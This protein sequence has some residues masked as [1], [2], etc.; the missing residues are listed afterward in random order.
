[1]VMLYRQETAILARTPTPFHVYL[2][3]SIT[4]S[5]VSPGTH[6]QMVMLRL[7]ASVSL[8]QTT[9]S[10]AI[11]TVLIR[12]MPSSV[13]SA[14]YSYSEPPTALPASAHAQSATTT[15]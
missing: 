4:R 12:A 1:M 15:T 11:S 5:R 9:V 2:P 10:D 3:I 13:L 14:S 6:L 8:V 7:A